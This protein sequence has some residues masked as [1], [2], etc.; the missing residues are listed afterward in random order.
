MRVLGG[1]RPVV[2]GLALAALVLASCGGGTNDAV[3][4]GPE[5][6]G[7]SAGGRDGDPAAAD[8]AAAD[9]PAIEAPVAEAPAVEAPTPE[10]D[11]E[12]GPGDGAA[13]MSTPEPGV[14]AAEWAN[15]PQ[16][17]WIAD[18][19]GKPKMDRSLDLLIELR[20]E[21]DLAVAR[22]IGE[23][24]AARRGL[25]LLEA[26]PVFLLRREDVGAFFF[27]DP[28]AEDVAKT[29]FVERLL[30]LLGV[31]GREVSLNDLFRDLFEGLVLGFYDSDL[32]A[33]VVI[34]ANDH[35]AGGDVSTMTHE[36][37]HALQD[38]HFAISDYFEEHEDNGDRILAARFVV[39]G[40]ARL[41]EALFRDVESEL[42]AQLEQRQDRLPGLNG[43]APGLLQV[44]FSAPYLNGVHA[45]QAVLA[46]EGQAGVDAL[47][48]ALPPST[49]QLLHPQKLALGEAPLAVEAPEVGEALGE[50]WSVLGTTT[51]GEFQLRTMLAGGVVG[52]AAREA[53]AGW[54]GDRLRLYQ[55]EEGD[56]GLLAWRLDWDD[57]D[58]AA[59]FFRV[60]S[61]WIRGHTGAA[62]QRAGDGGDVRALGEELS[63]WGRI[64]G[65]TTWVVIGEEA[66]AVERAARALGGV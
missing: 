65:A 8:A 46:R 49:E 48:A 54:G 4:P 19:L 20:D 53:A 35:I 27:D 64:A 47:L 39:E 7:G 21:A 38:Q 50:G 26:V 41:S 31:I 22:R 43:R 25:P 63:A 23:T 60:L 14:E 40:D 1:G 57:A 32:R 52:G 42:A 17:P 58:E 15:P 44:I 61:D 24:V 56:G 16:D 29:E 55:S 51:W 36:Y 12:A 3:A 30:A 37:V 13:A 33:F 6:T 2:A 9:A 66:G 10:A 59:E 28:D 18:E 5:A 45:I 11:V 34:S 62:V